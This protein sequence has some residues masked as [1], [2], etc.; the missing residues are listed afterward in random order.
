MTGITCK[1]VK[2]AIKI[3]NNIWLW[4]KKI[5]VRE[6]KQN[7]FIQFI[8]SACYWQSPILRVSGATEVNM[9]E[10]VLQCMNANIK[11]KCTKLYVN[12]DINI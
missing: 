7:P 9:T 4:L 8:L 5:K 1:N 6:L 2:Q 10:S 12:K 11:V 3:E